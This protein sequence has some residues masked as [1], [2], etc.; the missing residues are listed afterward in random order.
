MGTGCRFP[1]GASSPS[2]LWELLEEPCDLSKEVPEHRFK[3]AGFYHPDGEHHGTTNAP[4]SY[5]IEQ[6]HRV[7]DAS[8]FNI[9]PKEAEA[10]DP[11]QKMLLEVV[12]EA[13]ESAGI[14]IQDFAGKKVSCFIGSMTADFDGLTQKDEQTSSQYC[15]TGTSRAIISNRISYFFDWKG[16]SM[17]IDTACSSSLVAIH[18]AVLGLRDGE[19]EAACV[20]GANVMLSPENFIAEASLHMLSPTGKSRMWDTNADGYARGEG[21]AAVILKTLS[22]ALADGDEIEGIIR[23]SG[24][25]SD[26]RSKGITMPSSELQAELIHDTYQ[27]SGLNPRDPLDMPQY[28][29]AHGTGTQA[30]DPREAGAICRSF[31][32]D[33]ESGD[34]DSTD[35]PDLIVGSIKTVIGHTEGAAGLAGLIKAIL[36][37]KHQLIPPN[38]HLETLNPSVAPFCKHLK[39]PKV[40]TAWPNPAPGRPCRA[41]VNSFGFGGTNAHAILERYEPSIHDPCVGRQKEAQIQ[42]TDRPSIALPLML[43]AASDKSLFKVVEDCSAFL[44]RKSDINLFNLSWTL[45]YRRSRLPQKIAFTGLTQDDIVAKMDKQL[46]HVSESSDGAI[47]SRTKTSPRSA[48]IL[49]VFTGQGAQWPSMSRELLTSSPSFR[50]TI[51]ELQKVLDGCPDPPSWS[52]E[53][54]LMASPSDSRLNQAAFSQPLCTAVQVALVDVLKASGVTFY[55]V[56]GH[57]SGEIAAAYVA[58]RLSAKAAILIAYYRGFHAKLASGPNGS[59]GGMMA[60]GMD[61]EEAID[62]CNQPNLKARLYVAASNAPASVTLSGDKEAIEEAKAD[63]DNRQKF[64][65]MLMVDTAYHSHHMESC[66][67]PYMD[68][69][70]GCQIHA[71]QSNEICSWVSS[72][73]GPAGIPSSDELAGRY[74]REN[75]V[76][77]VL[78]NEALER[79]LTER[80]PFDAAIEVGPHAALKGPVTQTMK[81]IL[82]SAIPYHGTLDRTKHDVLALGDCIS[83]LWQLPIAASVDLKGYASNFS[84]K[85]HQSPQVVKG[86]PTYSWDHS[87]SHY[88]ESRLVKQYLGKNDLP[89]ELLGVRTSDDSTQELRWRNILKPSAIAWLKDHK[90]QGRIIVPAAA[91]CIMALE[92]ARHLAGSQ[93]TQMVELQGLEIFNAISAEEDSQGIETIFSLFTTSTDTEVIEASFILSST[94]VDGNLPLRKA[95]S[96]RVSIALGNPHSSLLPQ[97]PKDKPEMNAVDLEA[98]YASMQDIGLGYT[99]P[100]RA[101]T[102]LQRRM[103]AS[104]ATLNKPH[105]EDPCKLRVR[106]PL[107]DVCFQAAFAAFAAPGDGALWTAFL[108][109]KIQRLRFNLALCD[110]SP[111]KSSQLDIDAYITEFCPTTSQSKASFSGDIEIFNEQGQMEIQIEGI[112]VAS[113]ASNTEADDRELYLQTVWGRDSFCGFT[114]VEDADTPVDHEFIDS[115]QRMARFY[116]SNAHHHSPRDRAW[117]PREKSLRGLDGTF[118]CSA[119]KNFDTYENIERLIKKSSNQAL[120]NCIRVCGEH[121]PSLIPG[122]IDYAI[123]EA[124]LLSKLNHQLDSVIKQISHRYPRLKILEIGSDDVTTTS[125]LRSFGSA[126]TSYTVARVGGQLSD[127]VLNI[128]KESQSKV[129]RSEF[130]I[131]QDALDQGYIEQSYD[132][133]IAA[134]TLRKA[135][136]LEDALKSIRGLVRPGGYFIVLDSTVES[137]RQKFLRC[138]T[139]IPIEPDNPPIK[140]NTALAA[141]GFGQPQTFQQNS[142]R[143]SL[144]VC[145]AT[146]QHTGW[147][148]RPLDITHHDSF[149]GDVL[150]VGGKTSAV[151]AI[152][153]HLLESLSHWNG[154]ITATDSFEEIDPKIFD[155]LRSAVIL[156]DLDE[157]IVATMSPR[158]LKAL[159]KIFS[160]NRQ[161]LWLVSGFR[162]DNPYHNASVGIGR[163]IKA[164]TPNLDL[165]FLDLDVIEG[166]GLLVSETFLRLALAKSADE[167]SQLWTTEHEIVV[168]NSKFLIPRILPVEALNDRLNSIRRVVAREVS[169]VDNIVE[170][171]AAAETIEG[172]LHKVTR[173]GSIDRAA[174]PNDQVEVQLDYSSLLA[175]KAGLSR[176]LYVCLGHNTSSGKRVIALSPTNSSFIRI[177]AVSAYPLDCEIGNEAAFLALVVSYLVCQSMPVPDEPGSIILYEPDEFV[178]FALKSFLPMGQRLLFFASDPGRSEARLDWTYINPRMSSRQVK[179]LIPADVSCIVDFS[180]KENTKASV[181]SDLVPPGTRH[182]P[183]SSFF[184]T[185]TRGPSN[186]IT[187]GMKALKEAVFRSKNALRSRPPSPDQVIVSPVRRIIESGHQSLLTIVKWNEG[188]VVPEVQQQVKP[189]TVFS[190]SGTYLLVGLTGELGQSLSQL[191]VQSGVRYLVVVSRNP[192]KQPKW[193]D[194]LEAMGAKVLIEAVD[195]ANFADVVRLRDSLARTMPPVSGIVNG[196][197]VLSDGLFADMSLDSF[198]KVLRPKVE[199]SLNLDRAFSSVNLDFFIMFSSLT[200]VA[201]NRGQGNYAA[202]NMVRPIARVSLK[203]TN[204]SFSVHG[205]SCS[206]T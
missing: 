107:L 57:S 152:R 74:W 120:L 106:P 127:H 63:L 2:K 160:P 145:Q 200:A 191:M 204:T 185:D 3:I 33:P 16:P 68:S 64:A 71:Q 139:S 125:I 12:Y 141:A 148:L 142:G 112:N 175:V 53:D 176:H 69:L 135:G 78:F 131:H 83:F 58:G 105:P 205:R 90:F 195:A 61:V 184:K 77:A 129:I 95:V 70:K 114:A 18:Q 13:M 147:L 180:P 153:Q 109:Q 5:W 56:V 91:Y 104:V 119:V 179:S 49:G 55:G 39:I 31:F 9:T 7:F 202:A 192:N 87:Q 122:M 82:G 123:Q 172:T 93:P 45:A 173:L 177:P 199:G 203:V 150:I 194:W 161:V 134:F 19:A 163:C 201:G 30:G 103:N 36:S 79:I 137:F 41:S 159:Q 138:I 15:A 24:V 206:S 76:Q 136:S 23:D 113:F 4:K 22:K 14:P 27:K 118:S 60:A 35:A 124:S 156:A 174:L 110:V 182:F 190:N 108:P 197:M 170:I 140:W 80:G 1:G 198:Q 164:E 88:R 67:K 25:N 102:S 96:G 157:S 169:T 196:A 92:A 47:G 193:R 155:T 178:A 121:M 133:V 183:R 11:Q 17:T 38:Q 89:H 100:F 144:T 188:L 73:Y 132:L 84:D 111:G 162:Q 48:R 101:L 29:E 86:L 99:G 130:D 66:G 146:D 167:Q 52:I 98:F 32:G 116:L 85:V 115:C 20:G 154:Q 44:K 149:S 151:E 26:G 65:R 126:F 8:F 50:D 186:N 158:K 165:Q 171:M 168:Q 97:R 59:A 72:V 143:L 181:L 75:M 62:F 34:E 40:I 94:A 21:V 51:R 37:M 10:I 6:D 81:S 28:F 43:S 42:V 46:K 117:S 166:S 189:S 128:G 54:E 187:L